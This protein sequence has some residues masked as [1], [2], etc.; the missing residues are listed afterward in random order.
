MYM[1]LTSYVNIYCDPLGTKM[2]FTTGFGDLQP[3]RGLGSP[4]IHHLEVLPLVPLTINYR[5]V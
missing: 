2:M 1:E 4:L 3:H 5:G